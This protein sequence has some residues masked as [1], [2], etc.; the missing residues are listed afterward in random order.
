MTGRAQ[1]VDVVVIG[2][3]LEATSEQSSKSAN[4]PSFGGIS[5]GGNKV[6]IKATV[7]LQADLYNTSNGQKLSLI[8]I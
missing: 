2:T 5:I 6:S 3:V 7:T 4:L 1:G 8:H